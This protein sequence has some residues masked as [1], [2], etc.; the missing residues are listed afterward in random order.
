MRTGGLHRS[1][2]EHDAC[3][4]AFVADLKGRRTHDI[5]AMGIGALCNLDHRGATGADPDVGDG[6]GVLD[7]GARSVPQSDRAI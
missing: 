2:F 5:V 3:G 1:S 7:P 4:L 6:A